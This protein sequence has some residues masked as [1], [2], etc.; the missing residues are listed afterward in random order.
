[1][2]KPQ[3]DLKKA[4]ET[5]VNEHLKSIHG[6]YESADRVGD[7]LVYT[8]MSLVAEHGRDVVMG[9]GAGKMPNDWEQEHKPF[10]TIANLCAQMDEEIAAGVI[11]VVPADED[12]D[13]GVEA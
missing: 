9:I 7:Q 11:K 4:V 8:L 3:V 5:I 1:M 6:L 2:T 13:E 10:G 12:E